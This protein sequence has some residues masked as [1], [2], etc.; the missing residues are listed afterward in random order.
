MNTKNDSVSEQQKNLQTAPY[1]L[2]FSKKSVH[3]VSTRAHLRASRRDETLTFWVHWQMSYVFGSLLSVADLLRDLFRTPKWTFL[4]VH[5]GPKS[6][7]KLPKKKLYTLPFAY[8]QLFENAI[9]DAGVYYYA[10]TNASQ[11]SISTSTSWRRD[12]CT[13]GT[14]AGLARRAIG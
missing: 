11:K 12:W 10:L 6:D 2:Q 9:N 8:L 5:R 4:G 14:V 1:I 13:K 7:H 3:F